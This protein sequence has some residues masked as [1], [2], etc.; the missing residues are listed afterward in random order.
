MIHGRG[1]S[2][3]L[4]EESQAYDAQGRYIRA[5]DRATLNKRL[6]DHLEQMPNVSLH[7]NHKLTGADFEK[8]VAWFEQQKQKSDHAQNP[9]EN[10][11]IKAEQGRPAE[12]SVDFDFLIGA[13]GAHSAA[14]YHM[15][16]FAR[17]TYQQ[18]YIDTLW[19]EFHIAPRSSDSSFAISPNHLHIWP[20]G[21]FMF[22]AI[23]SLDKS[24]TCTLFAP[25]S[26]FTF[27]SS[28]SPEDLIISF[29][30]NFPGVCPELIS[31]EDLRQQFHENPHLPLI[32]IKCTPYHYKS[33]VVI[34]GDAAHAMVPFYGQGMNAGL[35][36]V[37]VLFD[38]LDSHNVYD[39][40]AE[41]ATTRKER[42]GG[43]LNAYTAQRTPDA[44]AINDLA[45]RNYEEMRSGVKSPVYRLR[46]W[47]EETVNVYLPRLGWRTQYS[48]VSF[49]NQRYSEVERAVARQG[50][51]IA[52]LLGLGLVGLGGFTALGLLR[53]NALG[54]FKGVLCR[55]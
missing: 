8:N 28:S 38:V 26:Y 25:A 30:R 53:R 31:P 9:T 11:S 34:L 55:L 1:Q 45:L 43:A 33:S 2:G 50:R 16:K 12:I 24:F 4:Y 22:I 15:M 49:E 35:E 48:R 21:S 27:L 40:S 10:T 39:D 6:L 14:R 41:L 19:C 5:V 32:S 47:L 52:T 46:K 17:V 37:R 44:A 42:R 23:P 51:I 29:A 13:D 36:D 7:F 18:E 3:E 54:Y 20:G